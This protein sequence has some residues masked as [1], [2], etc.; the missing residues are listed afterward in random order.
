MTAER[1]ATEDRSTDDGPYAAEEREVT[2]YVDGR[3]TTRFYCSSG[4][5]DALAVGWLLGEGIIDSARAVAR[6]ETDPEGSCIRVELHSA[7][8]R[9]PDESG[10]RGEIGPGA[11]PIARRSAG[12]PAA[13]RHPAPVDVALLDSDRLHR[14]FTAMF[15]RATLRDAGGGVHTGALVS[16]GQLVTVLEDVGRHNLVDKLMGTAALRG[17]AARDVSLILT[18]RI[19]GAIA[20]KLCRAGVPGVAS[21]SVPTTLARDVAGACGLTIVGR[22]RRP[23]PYVYLP[24]PAASAR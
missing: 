24:T 11:D 4:H 13:R 1:S 12:A 2:L 18:A 6:T 17:L 16:E 7:P 10:E 21:M 14:L 23:Q 3:K 15:E 9:V 19:S 20:Y 22:A 5:L 8:S